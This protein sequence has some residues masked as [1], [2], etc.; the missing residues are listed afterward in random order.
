MQQ[1]TELIDAIKSNQKAL[2]MT[3]LSESDDPEVLSTTDDDGCNAL[4]IAASN[5]LTET[6]NAIL[7]SDKCTSDDIF[8]ARDYRDYNVLLCLLQKKAT[9]ISLQLF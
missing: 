9:L 5:G 2:V 7:R 3:I 6:V 4:M 8:N 1:N